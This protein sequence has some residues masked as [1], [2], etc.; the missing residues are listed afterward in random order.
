MRWCN[1]IWPPCLGCKVD[2]I[3]PS[4]DDDV[5]HEIDGDLYALFCFVSLLL[6]P[7]HPYTYA[8]G[9]RG[10]GCV[11]YWSSCKQGERHSGHSDSWG[12]G[13]EVTY[14]CG[15]RR[16]ARRNTRMQQIART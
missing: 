3:R 13:Q 5:F 9:W 11:F 16:R 12:E 4:P 6:F 8:R 2:F 10:L 1:H 7:N 14:G 15:C